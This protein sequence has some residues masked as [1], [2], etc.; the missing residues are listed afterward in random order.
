[1]LQTPSY[2]DMYTLVNRRLNRSLALVD[3]QRYINSAVKFLQQRIGFQSMQEAYSFSTV[4]G[5]DVYTVNG[6]WKKIEALYLVKDKGKIPLTPR[7]YGAISTHYTG[8]TTPVTALETKGIPTE[9]EI[10]NLNPHVTG[11]AEIIDFTSTI[12]LRP[13]PDAVYAMRLQG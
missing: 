6:N 1:M 11:S 2:L 3:P 10:R 7:P 13:Q 9:Y 12:L 8:G 5:T 4:N